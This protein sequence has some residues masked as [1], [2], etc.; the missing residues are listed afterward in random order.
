MK[1]TAGSAQCLHGTTLLSVVP[2]SS[3]LR[4]NRSR[5]A[6]ESGLVTA[7]SLGRSRGRKPKTSFLA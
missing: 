6:L 4:L 1:P 7:G 5:L 2:R 3:V